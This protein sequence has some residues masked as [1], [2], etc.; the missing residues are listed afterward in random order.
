ME[1]LQ[2]YGTGKRKTAIARVWLRPGKGA[3]TVNGSSYESYFKLQSLLL[4]VQEPLKLTNTQGRFDVLV[5][6][7]GGG[8]SGQAE[9]LSHGI[10]KA[11]LENDAAHREVLKRNG[12][13]TR[14]SRIKE[15]KKYGQRGARARFQ[16]S[17]R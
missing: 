10:S 5:T 17:K 6:I 11:L 12:L 7:T 2:Y 3:I 8:P 9:A 16:F 13:L 4:V 1:G 14:D 15:R